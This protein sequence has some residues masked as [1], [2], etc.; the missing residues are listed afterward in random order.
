[1]KRLTTILAAG[2]LALGGLVATAPAA[3]ATVYGWHNCR[4]VH[5]I[6]G[7]PR[8]KRTT[9]CDF[10]TSLYTQRGIVRSVSY[11]TFGK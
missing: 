8:M 5:T 1:M 2:A 7:W 3:N 11:Y 10:G 4:T 9:Y 6:A